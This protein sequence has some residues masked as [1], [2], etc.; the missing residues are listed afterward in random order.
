MSSEKT[1]TEYERRRK[2]IRNSSNKVLGQTGQGQ[3][4]ASSIETRSFITSN[5]IRGLSLRAA[6]GGKKGESVSGSVRSLRLMWGRENEERQQQGREM[7]QCSAKTPLIS[8]PVAE[9]AGEPN[10]D[11]KR[12]FLYHDP[13][14]DKEKMGKREKAG[15]DRMRGLKELKVV[16]LW[17]LMLW[18]ERRKG[19]R[20][21]ELRRR[22]SER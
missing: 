11:R 17:D 6:E 8:P 10:K 14:H 3:E 5:Q 18:S 15:C 16:T 19:E 1:I 21:S 13:N 12:Q 22:E 20:R 7:I 9:E 4:A 2:K